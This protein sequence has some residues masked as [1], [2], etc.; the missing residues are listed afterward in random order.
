MS[1]PLDYDQWRREWV[2]WCARQERTGTFRGIRNSPFT[3]R[4]FL[5]DEVLGVWTVCGRAVELSSVVFPNLE[6]R[7]AATGKLIDKRIRRIGITFGD[8][9]EPRVV[10]SFS[11]LEDALGIGAPA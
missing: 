7:D 1:F 11:E 4:N 10:G 3:G 8:E 6:E 9:T 5:A 2:A